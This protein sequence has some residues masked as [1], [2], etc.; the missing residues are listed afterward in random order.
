MLVSFLTADAGRTG[1]E[2]EGGLPPPPAWSSWSPGGFGALRCFKKTQ[3]G[4][5]GTDDQSSGLLWMLL[6]TCSALDIAP[7]WR[8]RARAGSSEQRLHVHNGFS[9]VKKKKK[10]D[11]DWIPLLHK[12]LYSWRTF[13]IFFF[14]F[15]PQ[16]ELRSECQDDVNESK[17]K[18][19][20]YK[21]SIVENMA[22]IVNKDIN[23]E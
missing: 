16:L 8:H 22:M 13:R 9:S 1:E 18:K 4:I 5:S 21:S 12:V 19:N 17:R 2:G 11:C 23:I 3:R 7:T 10:K 20:I 15:F 6:W 14:G